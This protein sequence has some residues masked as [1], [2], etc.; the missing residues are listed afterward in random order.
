[1]FL[2]REL[3]K[4]LGSE[5]CK[6]QNFGATLK[7]HDAFVFCVVCSLHGARICSS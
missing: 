6:K 3:Q 5:F 1:M 4:L 7:N 2:E